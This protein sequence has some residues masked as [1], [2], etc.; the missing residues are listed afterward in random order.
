MRLALGVLDPVGVSER[1]RGRL[2]RRKY[3]C[4]VRVLSMMVIGLSG[5]QFWEISGKLFQM[6]SD[7]QNTTTAICYM[8]MI[9][10]LA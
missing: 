7:S 6:W 9:E 1:R 4:K 2:I 3:F 8:S 5:V 10:I